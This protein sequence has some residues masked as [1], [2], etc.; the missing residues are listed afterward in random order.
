MKKFYALPLY[1][2][3]MAATSLF[4]VTGCG[5]NSE[6][7]DEDKYDGP[8]EAAMFEI[9]RTKDPATGKV[10]WNK[11]LQAKLNTE[12]A[13]EAAR[14]SNRIQA[15]SW[16]ERGSNGDFNGPQG[17]SRPNQDQTAGRIRAAMVDSLDPTHKTVWVGGVD[18]GLWK[19]TDITA[20][21]ATWTLVNDF[22]SNLAVAAICQDPRPGF[23][24]NMYFCTGE[25]FGNA[26]AVQGVGVFKS[27]DGGATWNFLS[28]TT[29]FTACTRIICDYQ[30]NIYLGTR[31]SGLQRSMDGGSTWTNITPTGIGTSVCDL[32]ISSTS[33][34]SRLH[35][36]TGIFSTSGYR[37]TDIPTTVTAGSGWTTPVT[38]FTTFNQRTEMAILGN[39]LYALPDNSSHQ[40][41]T[42]WKSTDGGENWVATTGQ[43][44]S[45]W[46]SGQGWYSLSAG[47]HPSDPDQ[48]IVG[49]LDTY[50]TINGGT[51]W[52]KI[53]TW[54]STVGQYV[55]ADQHNVQW[56]DGGSKLMFAC[57]GG[58][59]YSV[60]NGTTIRDRNKGL[61]LKQFYSV[62]I[63]PTQTNYFLAG[64]QDNGVHRLNHPGL[65]SSIEV[66][67][68]DGCYVAI[69]QNEGQYQFGSYVYNVFRRSTNNGASWS[70]PVNN[71]STGR[72]VNPW[73]YDNNANI[74]YSCNNT[75]TFLRW[76]NPQTGSTTNVVTAT[77]F[78]GNVSA[79][80][81]SPYT[82]N[83]VY[84]GMGA[85]GAVF[86]VNDA[87]VGTTVTAANIT[88]AGA[89]GYVNCVVTGSSD[90]HLIATCT[91]YNITN[92]WVSHNGGTSWTA[93]DGNLPNMPVRWAL[94]HPDDDNKAYIATET[95]V[96]E[97][98]LLNGGSTVWV[99][100]PSFP[101]VRTDMI[102]YR[103]SDRTIA[104]GTHGRGVWSA[105]IPPPSGFSFGATTPATTACPAPAT[106]NVT[107]PTIS[108]GGFTNPITLSATA[109]VP[110]GTSISFGTNPVVPGN[111]S[112]IT[113][114][115]ANTLSPGTYTVTIQ[116]TAA[117]APNQ[118]TTVSF[119]IT[120]GAGPV[121]STQPV[122][123]TVCEGQNVTFSVVA[124]GN[125][126][127]QVSTNGGGSWAALAGQTSASYTI[128]GVTT[129]LNNNQYRC[130]VS[131][132][133]GSTTSNAAVLTVSS[134]A[135]ITGQPA[136]LNLC[137]GSPATF[138]VTAT[139]T[140]LTYQWESSTSGCAG[141]WTDISGATSSCYTIASVTAGMNNTAYR[142]KVTSSCGPTTINTSCALL[143]V[144][145]SVNVTTQPV[146]QVICDGAAT[147]FTVAG[148]GSGI[149]YQW[150]VNTG[151]GFAN[152]S[153]GGV[154]GG[155]ATATLTLTGANTIYNGYQ[156]R[157]LLSNSTCTTPGTSAAATLTVNALPAITSNPVSQTIC[158]GSN[159]SFSTTAT[160]TGI[161]YQWR[162]NTG[163]GFVNVTDAGAYSGANSATLNITGATIGFNGY[164]YQCVVS[165]T[166]SP[167][168]T[169][170]AATLTVH[171]PVVVTNSP[172]NVER[173][174]GS[175]ASFGVIGSSVPAIN[176]QWQVSTDGGTSWT[177]LAGATSSIY[178]ANGVTAGMNNN[179]YRCLL[180][181]NTCTTP[182]ASADAIL[183]VRVVP[184]VGLTAAPLTSLL[185]GQTTTLTATPSASTGGSIRLSWSFNGSVFTNNANT[186]IADVSNLGQYQVRVTE[187]WPNPGGVGGGLG[188]FSESPIVTITANVS[189]RLFIF[190]SPND[191]NFSVS[192]YNTGGVSTQR[193]IR[194][195][196]AKGAL[197]FDKVFPVSGPYTIIPVNL[198]QAS[199]GLYYVVV[200]DAAG[201]K[202]AEGKMHVR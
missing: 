108:G 89:T 45:G 7:V 91:N 163:A 116:G 187:V 80:H 182:V 133:C 26:D 156:Y 69:D 90:Q 6:L 147:S 115:N 88:P 33:G 92:I 66:T 168:A 55:H 87:N 17:N 161:T 47:I 193:R 86:Y 180:S 64:A 82:A 132:L 128:T 201:K 99:A 144:V 121:I 83:K 185:P 84:F 42:I 162:V 27:T 9:E 95:G 104:A 14:Q 195:M 32:E 153:N 146:N 134:L 31:G 43:P 71:Q 103:A 35:V 21:T 198:T 160:G 105:I 72:F 194:V 13:R 123:Q 10:P 138:C 165:G 125:Y 8:D 113:L 67:G 98:D 61:R 130:V 101:N 197:V 79:V 124:T 29:A 110:A 78:T 143:T 166:C 11:L 107:L 136:D 68:G 51:T 181:N 183:T 50:K 119:T 139:G 57:D 24:N 184:T 76:D 56:W 199:R 59:H 94:F 179:R 28:S 15:L 129:A 114:N 152:I 172:A 38:A 18:G 1:V 175:N 148:S 111:S 188:C 62:A 170:T 154:Y 75:G 117:S 100:N 22:L 30:G 93:S 40:V 186:Y 189:D 3:I 142:C 120:A 158:T 46:A 48:C 23:Q 145:T 16:I 131:T 169:S 167:A 173:C 149:L 157:C 112:V 190:P 2:M 127:W 192:Y 49:G 74:I 97:T 151:S 52:V 102:K 65:D 141:T 106:M 58:I 202:L 150:Q 39:T 81:A 164:Q 53:S 44:T 196:D 70:T 85:S 122:S 73:D 60:D 200:G 126:Q 25:S 159:V 20:S 19:T 36:A 140:G 118:V 109:G 4:F 12:T 41:P 174:A 176:Y 63:H 177:A 171:A 54:A 137:V 96:W 5:S 155:A 191:G 178:T 135:T 77:G 37:Y 34:P